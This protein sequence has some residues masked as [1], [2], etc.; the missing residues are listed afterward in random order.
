MNS[1]LDVGVTL[2]GEAPETQPWIVAHDRVLQ[3]VV[4]ESREIDEGHRL[5]FRSEASDLG[6][7]LIPGIASTREETL[8]FRIQRGSSWPVV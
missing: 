6:V 2:C 3:L 4:Q 8:G 7:E 5:G 1:T